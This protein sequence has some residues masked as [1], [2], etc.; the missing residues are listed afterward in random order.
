MELVQKGQEVVVESLK[1]I[2]AKMKWTTAADFDLA[3]AYETKSGEKGMVY[4]GTPSKGNLNGFPFMKLDQD[5]GIG[6]TGGDNEENLRIT[7]LDDMKAVHLICWDYG[8]VQ[9]GAPARFK[10]SD[11]SIT[12]TNDKG[13]TN[14][15]NCDAGDA[16]NTVILA[17]I[18]N[19]SPIGARLINVSKAGTLKGLSNSDQLFNIVES[20]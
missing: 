3:A 5:S 1:A 16:G 13:E 9:K 19:S 14:T 2:L 8:A 18:D 7:K 15:V 12:L 17:T 11:L 20:A 6:D 4:F 10:G